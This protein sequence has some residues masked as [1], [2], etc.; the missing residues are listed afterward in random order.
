M[1]PKTGR[2]SECHCLDLFGSFL[3]HGTAFLKQA[4]WACAEPAL[5]LGLR[6]ATECRTFQKT[7]E[8]GTL[9]SSAPG[10]EPP[11]RTQELLEGAGESQ[12]PAQAG[13]GTC[14]EQI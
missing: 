13:G 9:V 2:G 5:A 3:M 12:D 7:R 8:K 6:R 4:C 14:F 11:S 10:A 1:R